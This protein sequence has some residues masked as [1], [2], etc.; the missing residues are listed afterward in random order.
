MFA[1][2]AAI[3]AA[4]P[5]TFG[6][7][8]QLPAGGLSLSPV[9]PLHS[10]AG[11]GLP[12]RAE[13]SWGLCCAQG[14]RGPVCFKLF[15]P[16]FHGGIILALT[17]SFG[18]MLPAGNTFCFVFCA[19]LQSFSTLRTC[20]NQ[21]LQLAMREAQVAFVSTPKSWYKGHQLTL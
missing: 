16:L 3:R 5:S 21:H 7:P 14:E 13:G 18:R 12:I 20:S 8:G 1:G 6:R 10:A 9:W 11:P 17:A 19:L 4:V 15:S 2:P